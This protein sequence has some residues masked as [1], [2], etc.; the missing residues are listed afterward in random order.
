MKD[1]QG[2]LQLAYRSAWTLSTETRTKVG[3]VIVSTSSHRAEGV[4]G[5]RACL[6]GHDK[7]DTLVHAEE[8][9]IYSAARYAVSTRGATMFA[10]WACCT[11]C[12]RAIIESGIVLLVVHKQ[13][14]DRTPA[15]WEGEVARGRYLLDAAGVEVAVFDGKIGGC[16]SVMDG[17][18][19]R[20]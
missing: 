4:N 18:E 14:M 20:P 19:W 15:R 3:A 1:F 7:T 2:M 6:A 5:V 10:P 9:A 8:A 12:A 11:R 17:K 13:A 16:V